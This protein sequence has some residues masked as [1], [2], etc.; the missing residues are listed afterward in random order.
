MKIV[1]A[2]E[3]KKKKG[4]ASVFTQA[5]RGSMGAVPSQNPTV[6]D[7]TALLRNEVL[8]SHLRKNG[9]TEPAE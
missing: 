1:L 5:R 9:H 4:K 6:K 8:G 3:K 7:G 2:R